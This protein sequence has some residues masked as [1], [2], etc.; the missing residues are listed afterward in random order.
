MVYLYLYFITIAIISYL[1][2]SINTSIIIGKV[3]GI[4]IR[5]HGSGNAGLTNTLRTLGKGAAGMVL[6]GDVLKAVIAILIAKISG[7]LFQIIPDGESII[8]TIGY[9]TMELAIEIAGIAVVLGHIF[10]IYYK[11][12]GGKGVLTSATVIFMV[13]PI[14]G[15]ICLGIFAIIVAVTRYVSL[16]SVI[17]AFA[18]PFLV[19]CFSDFV[20][21]GW[22]VFS[23]ILAILVIWGHRGNLKR[24][25]EGNERKLSFKRKSENHK[26]LATEEKA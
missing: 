16:G 18:F 13:N 12:K 25:W 1:L 17:G 20:T 9:S 8:M 15:L 26:E 3:K 23:F 4:D 6:L 7:P 5:E 19:V 21:I 2:G 11:F 22:M 24:I 10:P 14:I